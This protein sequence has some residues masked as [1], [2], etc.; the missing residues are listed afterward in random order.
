MAFEIDLW[1]DKSTKYLIFRR[2][3]HHSNDNQKKL[4]KMNIKS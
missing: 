2:E 1:R 3:Q 4:F